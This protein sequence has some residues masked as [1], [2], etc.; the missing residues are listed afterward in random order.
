MKTRAEFIYA[1]RLFRAARRVHALERE[2]AANRATAQ[3]VDDPMTLNTLRILR[4]KIS[5]ELAQ[6]RAAWA[7]LFPPG[8]RHTWEEA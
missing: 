8:V 2:L 1:Y 4:E 7:A 6:A 5:R 3:W